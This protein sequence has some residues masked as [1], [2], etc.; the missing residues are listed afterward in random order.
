MDT[1]QKYPKVRGQ[2]SEE[3]LKYLAKS[4]GFRSTVFLG[5]EPAD[6]YPLRMDTFTL[7]LDS[8]AYD[9]RLHRT[10]NTR[11]ANYNVKSVK[12]A[13]GHLQHKMLSFSEIGQVCNH[14]NV[15]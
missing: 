4:L 5:L 2:L 3:E 1:V 8:R 10:F 6:K 13:L 14:G 11:D 7:L 15:T 12:S 9:R